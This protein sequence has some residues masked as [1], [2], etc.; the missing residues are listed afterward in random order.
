ML[1]KEGIPTSEQVLSKFPDISY[2][3]KPKAII[4]CYENIPCNPCSTSCPV[5]AIYIGENINNIPVVDFDKCTGCGICAYSCPGLSII[6]CKVSNEKAHFKIPYE[7]LPAP[8]KGEVWD[9]VDRSGKV[10]GEAIIEKVDNRPSQ[11][12]TLLVHVEVDARL[13][14]DFVTIRRRKDG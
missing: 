2:L 11:D 5:K 3:V 1:F 14:Y 6:V 13:L 4:E 8:N 10:I 12:K 7:F 9:A